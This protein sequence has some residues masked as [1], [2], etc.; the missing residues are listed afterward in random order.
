MSELPGHFLPTY[1]DESREDALF[2]YTTA[3][4]LVGMVDSGEIWGT[5]YYCANDEQELSA[6][7]GV[8]TPL[9]RS[10]TSA[11]LAANDQRLETFRQRGLDVYQ[12][13]DHFE[14]QITDLALSSL[15]AYIT[16][17]C[18]PSANEDFLHGLLSQWRGYGSDGGYAIQF[19][20]KKLIA[21]IE[22]SNKS[23]ALN[24]DIQDVYYTPE[25]RLRA[26]VLG[27]SALI[28]E[29]YNRYLDERAKPLDFSKRSVRNPLQDLFDGPLEA[30]LDY[31][32]HTKNC[33]F[34]EERECRLSLIQPVS[35]VPGA[36]PVKYFN[37]N[38][39]VVPYTTTSKAPMDIL[40]C[41]EWI[42]VG[43]G[44]RMGARFKSVCQM[45][46]QSGR[47]IKVR[48]SRIPFTRF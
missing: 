38:G 33:H 10:A 12:H 37:R 26:A 47:E 46:K 15:C 34:S 5:A 25:N 40:S 17:F 24:Y 39:L 8:L 19:S 42:V 30:L 3:T 9:L 6:G 43:P 16:C 48:V 32:I 45:L 22:A 2:H 35:A 29:A 27:H 4:G 36:R 20:R 13:A 41:I 1:S 23:E 7:K 31:L 21:A 11:M 14:Q 44:A 18:K 28:L